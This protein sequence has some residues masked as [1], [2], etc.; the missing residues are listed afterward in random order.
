MKRIGGSHRVTRKR[1]DADAFESMRAEY[2]EKRRRQIAAIS[3]QKP[4]HYPEDYGDPP[5]WMENA[6]RIMEDCHE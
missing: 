2:E 5:P 3:A 4:P 6:I 1:T